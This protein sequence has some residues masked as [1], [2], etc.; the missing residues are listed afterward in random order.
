VT[1][2]QAGNP[3]ESGAVVPAEAAQA[4]AGRPAADQRRRRAGC[5][6]TAAAA[7]TA[8]AARS[9]VAG[10]RLWFQIATGIALLAAALVAVQ[11]R[12][13]DC[14]D[15]LRRQQPGPGQIPPMSPAEPQLRKC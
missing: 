10:Y 12:S 6:A 8:H 7:R 13:G 14:Q 3:G 4:A 5:P 9:L 2:S 15:G 1:A 11:L